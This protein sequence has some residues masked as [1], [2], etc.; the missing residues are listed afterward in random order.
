MS[1]NLIKLTPE[2]EKKF[3]TDYAVYARTVGVDPNPD[4][5]RHY[6]DYRGAWKVENGLHPDAEGHLSS[7]FKLEGNPEDI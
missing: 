2:E 6:Y 4:D 7:R 3:Q 5:P 1:Q